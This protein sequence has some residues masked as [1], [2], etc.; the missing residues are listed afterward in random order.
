MALI[1][2]SP[3]AAR[4]V[5]RTFAQRIRSMQATL[6]QR[7]KMASLGTLA[8]GIAH[9]LNNPAAA[10]RR[11]AQHLG[12]SLKT[13]NTLCLTLSHQTLNAEQIGFLTKFQQSAAECLTA[14]PALDPLAE[15]ECEDEISGWL[16]AHHVS[17]GWKLAPTF[18][19]AGLHQEKLEKLAGC[20]KGA[21]LNDALHWLESAWASQELVREI[22]QSMSR[23]SE[24]VRAIKE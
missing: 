15:S 11:A 19:R 22:E 5:L 10:A 17:E 8:A 2:W 13:L 20:L 12:E 24:L 6:Q 16:D 21:A 18:V 14:A 1:D 4:V 7:E 23:I 3:G 9:E